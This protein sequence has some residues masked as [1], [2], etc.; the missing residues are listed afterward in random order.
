ME[1]IMHYYKI[2]ITGENKIWKKY[3]IFAERFM[4]NNVEINVSKT[5]ELKNDVILNNLVI[6][7]L[8]NNGNI[9]VDQNIYTKQILPDFSKIRNVFLI[10]EDILDYKLF[11]NI[12]GIKFITIKIDGTFNHNYKLL[13]FTN[14]INCVDYDKSIV[15]FIDHVSTIVLDKKKIPENIDGFFLSGWDKYG[16]FRC[17]IN[18]KLKKVL[19]KLEKANK[20]LLFDKVELN[21]Q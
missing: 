11:E 13:Y 9:V 5:I 20:I 6:Q 15:G 1:D 10:K 14:V 7:A 4:H 16:Q 17:I 12:N 21:I 8:D 3:I 2:R 18:E 19:E